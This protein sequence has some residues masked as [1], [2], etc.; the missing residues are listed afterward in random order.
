LATNSASP[1]N[2]IGAKRLPAQ[3]LADARRIGEQMIDFIEAKAANVPIFREL[4][5]RSD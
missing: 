1:L 5:R 2:G 4:D 3:N